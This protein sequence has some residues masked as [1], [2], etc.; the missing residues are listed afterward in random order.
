MYLHTE[1]TN[2]DMHTAPYTYIHTTRHL[3][4]ETN[5]PSS[6]S[7]PM[8]GNKKKPHIPIIKQTYLQCPSMV[9]LTSDHCLTLQTDC[10]YSPN[11]LPKWPKPCGEHQNNASN[12]EGCKNVGYSS[13][14]TL[15]KR[16]LSVIN[17]Y[18]FVSSNLVPNVCI[19]SLL[20]AVCWGT[21]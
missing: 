19:I 2:I 13:K 14:I 11:C 18:S 9:V 1:L 7:T 21:F 12:Q 10:C 20:W 8:S 16:N 4:S 15:R 17:S 5:V 6:A 3:S